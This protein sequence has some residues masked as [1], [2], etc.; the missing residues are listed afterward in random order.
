MATKTEYEVDESINAYVKDEETLKQMQADGQLKPFSNYFTPDEDKNLSCLRT[1]VIYDK[2][3]SEKNWGFASGI[4][5]S[6]SVSGKDFSKYETLIVHMQFAGHVSGIGFLDLQHI[7][8]NSSTY[9][10]KFAIGSEADKDIYTCYVEVNRAKTTFTNKQMGFISGTSFSDRNS[11]ANYY[12]YKIEGVL[13]EPAMIYTGAEL[14]EGNGIEIKDGVISSKT[15]FKI[16]HT[17]SAMTSA[18]TYTLNDSIDNYKML[19]F[20]GAY[21][22][23]STYYYCTETVTV[24]QYKKFSSGY[25]FLVR[26]GENHWVSLI[27]NGNPSTIQIT[28]VADAFISTVYGVK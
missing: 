24:D 3:I 13:K 8:P 21:K 10:A 19:I 5:G 22:V 4:L 26:S 1:E 14:H 6:K 7:S 17:G 27:Y 11:N 18:G 9:K 2:N 20:V 23:S 16:L 28:Y 12:V 15:E 25:E